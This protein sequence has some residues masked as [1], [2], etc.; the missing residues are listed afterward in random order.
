V[1]GVVLFGAGAS[2][3]C[4]DICPYQPPLG[5]DLYNELAS[6]FPLT[7]GRLPT[8]FHRE[9]QNDFEMA[10][11][12][13]TRSEEFSLNVPLLMRNMAE[14]F[15]EFRPTDDSNLYIKF[16]STCAMPVK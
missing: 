5:K 3:A 1:R 2:R 16:K 7:W 11:D 13:L 9:F 4:D 15:I 8:T 6:Y 10:M 14:Y 12:K